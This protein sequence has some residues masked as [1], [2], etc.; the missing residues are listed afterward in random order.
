MVYRR[1]RDLREDNDYTQAYVADKIN[2]AS[3]TYAYYESGER[4]IPPSVLLSLSEFYQVSIDY[5]L[6]RTDE[7]FLPAM[8]MRQGKKTIGGNKKA[9]NQSL[10]ERVYLFLKNAILL[11]TIPM[12]EMGCV[13]SEGDLAQL[14][15]C[16]VTPVRE[17]V[18]MLRRDGLVVTGYYRPSRVVSFSIKEI[19]DMY[20]IR[21]CL[22]AAAL[23]LAVDH[24]TSQDIDYLRRQTVL[25]EAAH[26]SHD[27]KQINLR[28]GEFHG[29]FL[30]RSGNTLLRSTLYQ[31]TEKLQMVRVP[32]L[33]ERW[34]NP[35]R[36]A[37]AA[38][39]DHRRIIEAIEAHDYEKAEEILSDHINQ[40]NLSVCAYY[41]MK[42]DPNAEQE[43]KNRRVTQK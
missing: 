8:M 19:Q 37:R 17:A 15:H 4:M 28:N 6:G 29:F 18:N 20:A 13:F 42:K 43:R 32:M 27:F 25:F 33:R 3:R 1:I 41:E 26:A 40:V 35:T 5:I 24:I 10:S 23:R 11:Q 30:E 39:E 14:L 31:F 36:P 2:V 7:P 38:V 12:L 22:E 34:S 9:E 21:I 16:S